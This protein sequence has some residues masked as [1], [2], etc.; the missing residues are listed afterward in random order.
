VAAQTRAP[1]PRRTAAAAPSFSIRPFF[2]ATVE[3]L[4]AGQTFDAV[5]GRRLAPFWGGGVELDLARQYFVEISVSRFSKTG[6][7]VFVSDGQVFPLGIPLTAKITPFEVA[8]G[9][10]F[11]TRGSV[12]PYVG[13]GVGRYAYS[14]TSDF[15]D[16]SDNVD[17]SNVGFLVFGGAEFRVHRWVGIGVDA[18]FTRV[19]GILGDGGASREFGETDLGGTGI[20]VRVLVGR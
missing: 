5:L 6:Q 10:R 12:V 3:A 19:S 1:A 4:A 8:G 14:E 15:A 13:A 20:R 16:A 9:Y 11:V 17:A 7:R 18:H 2:Q